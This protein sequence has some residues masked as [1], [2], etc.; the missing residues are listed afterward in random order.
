MDLAGLTT[1]FEQHAL[2]MLP[3]SRLRARACLPFPHTRRPSEFGDFHAEPLRSGLIRLAAGV[4][5]WAPSTP[6]PDRLLP[7]C[8]K[9]W[10]SH[11]RSHLHR[12]RAVPRGLQLIGHIPQCESHMTG[13]AA[14]RAAVVKCHET[15]QR[16]EESAF[17]V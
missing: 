14:D 17:R 8:A 13:N 10:S 1:M 4:Q 3:Q 11:R 9:P 6:A 7:A 16:H 15:V 5:H 12:A 2:S